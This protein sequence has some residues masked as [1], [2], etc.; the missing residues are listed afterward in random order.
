METF[1]VAAL[2]VALFAIK[3]AAVLAIAYAGCRLAWRRQRRT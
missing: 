2:V 1:T 3:G